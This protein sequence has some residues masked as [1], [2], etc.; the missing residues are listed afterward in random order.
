LPYKRIFIQQFTIIFGSFL[1]TAFNSPVFMV[2]ILIL[3]KMFFDIKLF[4]ETSENKKE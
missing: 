1:L 4:K 2:I 3:L